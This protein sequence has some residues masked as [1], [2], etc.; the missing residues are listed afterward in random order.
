MQSRAGVLGWAYSRNGVPVR[1][2][3]ERWAHIIEAH[4]YMAG[5]HEWVL[6]TV[7]DPDVIANGWEGSYVATKYYEQTP[8][9]SK[10]MVV[11]YREL[12]E[13]DGFIIT[14]FMTSKPEKIWKRGIIW[15]R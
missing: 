13:K 1:L 12:S 15:Q 8:I 14:A 5:L 3:Y 2:T 10:H 7:T 4:D 6:E 9:S 11:V